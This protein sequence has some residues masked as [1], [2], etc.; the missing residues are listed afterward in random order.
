M[1]LLASGLPAAT[2]TKAD[3]PCDFEQMV[4]PLSASVSSAIRIPVPW[5][6]AGK[7]TN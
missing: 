1:E 7:Q 4:H 3:K 2:L 6:Y 5:E